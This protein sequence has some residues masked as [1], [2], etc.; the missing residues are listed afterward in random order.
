MNIVVA[1][2][3]PFTI[4]YF[5]RQ[6]NS[7]F[8][9]D[10]RDI[11]I[12]FNRTEFQ[13]INAKRLEN[14]VTQLADRAKNP[15][16]K[17]SLQYTDRQL[18]SLEHWLNSREMV[19]RLIESKTAILN[20]GK[21]D[22]VTQILDTSLKEAREFIAFYELLATK[23]H[24]LKACRDSLE[25]EYIQSEKFA[26]AA[27]QISNSSLSQIEKQRLL[28]NLSGLSDSEKTDLKK[29]IQRMGA[30]QSFAVGKVLPNYSELTLKNVNITGINFEYYDRIYFAVS[31]GALDYRA[32]DFFR[33]DRR[34]KPQ[35]VYLSRVGYGPKQG[36]HIHL[37]AF[38]GKKQ[39]LNT[40]HNPNNLDIYGLS[41]EA[42]LLYKTHRVLAEI[43][44]SASPPLVNQGNHTE[45]AS[46]KVRDWKNKAWSFR[47]NS[48]FPKTKSKFEAFYRY[49]GINFQSFSSYYANAAMH[50]WQVGGVQYFWKKQLRLNVAVSRNNYENT[51]LPV[52]YTGQTNFTTASILFK[53]KKWPS[54]QIGYMPASQLSEID[55]QIY[56]NFYHAL[57][58]MTNY[59]YRLGLARAYSVFS[60]HRFYN[61]SKDTGFIYYNA[62]NYYFSQLFQF[63][64]YAATLNIARSQSSD[65]T[66]TVFETGI[67]LKIKKLHGAGVGVKI[68]QLNNES[69]QVGLYGNLRVL[70]PKV[71]E[72]NAWI[73]KAYLPAWNNQ[74]TRNE[75]C[76]IGFTRFFK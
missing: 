18:R 58:L 37:T 5:E 53:R 49:R 74:L 64:S 6:S 36:S 40:G 67:N 72:L 45:K 70:I 68:N 19:K 50:S 23:K 73:E 11:R 61:D 4:T 42:Q 7:R 41:L 71:G 16:L 59:N 3:L 46:F 14:Y 56:E 1:E 75:L 31:V 12:E 55:G 15:L 47:L 2:K 39:L 35:L 33:D 26:A 44:Q 25:K 24:R 60:Y 43:A 32:R 38:R 48:I 51:E 13:N 57:N 63:A 66:L 27:Q 28:Q 76:N 62:R 65:F 17:P 21:I 10:Y 34:R 29:R 52:R 9:R 20:G 69:V 30:I 54:L 22:S 8:F